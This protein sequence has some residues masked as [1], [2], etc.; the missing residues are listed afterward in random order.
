M[1]N[2]IVLSMATLRILSGS[3]ELIAAVVMLRLNQ[4]D[5]ALLVNSGLAVVGPLVLITTTA[6]GLIGI[7]ERLSFA[8]LLWILLGVSFIFIGILKK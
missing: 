4:V 2:K 1:L 8:K 6:I 5:K 7:A 3:L